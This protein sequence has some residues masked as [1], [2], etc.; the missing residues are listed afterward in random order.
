MDILK[1]SPVHLP[2]GLFY[3]RENFLLKDFDYCYAQKNL[4]IQLTLRTAKKQLHPKQPVTYEYLNFSLV[5]LTVWSF[6]MYQ[7]D[8]FEVKHSSHSNTTLDYVSLPKNQRNLY[9]L[10]SYDECF[11]IYATG[12]TFE[13]V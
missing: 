4:V 12:F 3:N 6:K 1:F 7:Y 2:F 9:L 10:W 8:E 5:F 13:E 11:E